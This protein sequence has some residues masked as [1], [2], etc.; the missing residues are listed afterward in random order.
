MRTFAPVLAAGFLLTGCGQTEEQGAV[1]QAEVAPALVADENILSSSPPKRSFPV[2]TGPY[3]PRDEC[4]SEA[5]WAVFAQRLAAAVKA[6]DAAGLATLADPAIVLDFGGG[7]G[8]EELQRRLRGDRGRE[9]WAELDAILRLGCAKGR[10]G[11]N[12]VLPWFFGQDLGE[13]DPYQ[14]LLVSADRVPLRVAP[15]PSAEVIALVAWHLADAAEERAGFRKVSLKDE[16][17]KG[18]I[19]STALRSPLDYRLVAQ[20]RDGEWRLMAFVAGD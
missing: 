16:E 1:T 13:A 15:D 3:A 19:A 10:E 4:G 5:G 18:Y 8:R 12:V 14:V 9:L 6:R 17:A 2:L 20:R 7:S 11:D